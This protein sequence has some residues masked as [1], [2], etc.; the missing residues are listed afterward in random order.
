M[1][2]LGKRKNAQPCVDNKTGKPTVKVLPGDTDLRKESD[3][4]LRF[5]SGKVKIH[6]GA[7]CCK[8]A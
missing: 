4:G 8:V 7:W 3:H 5:W 1:L 2:V 6:P